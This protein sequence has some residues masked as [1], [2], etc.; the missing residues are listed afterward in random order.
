MGKPYPVVFLLFLTRYNYATTIHERLAQ[1]AATR[2][3]HSS[4][5]AG[6]DQRTTRRLFEDC[7]MSA[8]HSPY[9]CDGAPCYDPTCLD[10]GITPHSHQSPSHIPTRKAALRSSSAPTPT[11]QAKTQPSSIRSPPTN[12]P[13]TQLP[14]SQIQVPYT[15]TSLS[16]FFLFQH[17]AGRAR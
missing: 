13:F 6:D 11:I 14:K 16:V 9:E 8:L 5:S 15:A 17:A 10:L 1:L 3:Q 7:N 12:Y 2:Q 4:Q